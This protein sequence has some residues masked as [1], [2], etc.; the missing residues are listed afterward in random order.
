MRAMHENMWMKPDEGCAK[1]VLSGYFYRVDLGE[2]ASPRHHL[3]REGTCACLQAEQCPA[4][5]AVYEYL[6]ADGLPAPE[7]IPGFYPVAPRRCPICRAETIPD[8]PLSSL[9]RGAGWLCSLAGSS[10]YWMALGIDQVLRKDIPACNCAM[11]M[12]T[13]QKCTHCVNEEV[14]KIPMPIFPAVAS[15]PRERD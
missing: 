8:R 2:M 5:G 1:V 6:N 3:I 11:Y 12:V 4:V 10:H 7:P 14:H 13:H 15:A 9:R